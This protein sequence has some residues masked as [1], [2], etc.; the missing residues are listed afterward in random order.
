MTGIER[1]LTGIRPTGPLHI[2]HY[3]GALKLWLSAQQANLPC[4]FL[5]ADI[6]AL[7]THADRFELVQG[8]VRKV[9]LDLISVGIDPRKDN[10]H[11]V[12]QS[13]V[14]S[15]A[16][17]FDLLTMEAKLKDT[18]NNPTIKAEMAQLK[19]EKREVTMGFFNYVVSQA[20]DILM[21]S[22]VKQRGNHLYVPV[23]A[24]QV[25]HLEATNRIVRGFN[26]TYNTNALTQCEGRVGEVGRLVGTDGDKK[27]SKSLGNAI[28]LSD[29]KEA[30]NA[31]I[32]KMYTDPQR[33]RATDTVESVENNPLFIY[34]R[35]FS[36]DQ[37]VV[38][39]YEEDYKAGKIGDAPLKAILAADI[40][41]MLEPM[42]ERRAEA[43]RE[44]LGDYLREGTEAAE[45]LAA[46]VLD[47]MHDAMHLGYQV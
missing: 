36:P 13:K 33:V 35:A 8:A 29:T 46:E 20:A 31:S 12:L 30:V 9:T 11:T 44:P 43:E 15:R 19:Q 23:G 16:A 24:D 45:K 22:P 1:V 41:N 39:Q 21:V 2:G 42:R 10:V 18:E 32:R 3:V 26:K 34:M 5:I 40:N 6:Q 14:T 25:P 37:E 47:R 38:N 7:T 28:M 17:I 27:M 4:Y